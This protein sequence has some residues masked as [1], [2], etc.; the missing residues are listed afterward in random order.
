MAMSQPHIL[1]LD[2]PTNHLDMDSIEALSKALTEFEG[3]LL[4][5]SH[6]QRF[7]DSVCQEV[8]ICD[9]STL[10]K[11]EG[12]AGCQDGIVYQ[13]KKSLLAG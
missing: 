11:F 3:G 12:K 7:L 9:N 4:I 8:W 1:I 6:D 5:V 13:Y 10:N 2:E